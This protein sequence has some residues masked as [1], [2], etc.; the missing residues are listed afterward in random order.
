MTAGSQDPGEIE[1]TCLNAASEILISILP[2]FSP[3]N[4]PFGVT[5]LYRPSP[6]GADEDVG[7]ITLLN[8]HHACP[9]EH[10]GRGS[11]LRIPT[12][13]GVN[14]GSPKLE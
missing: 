7:I 3:Q 12:V 4:N 13:E 10:S 8:P 5:I 2:G 1:Q 14:Q 6:P 9:D 11:S